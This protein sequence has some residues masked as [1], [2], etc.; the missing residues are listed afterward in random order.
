MTL[1]LTTLPNGLRVITD[2]VTDI[3]SAALGVWVDVGTRNENLLHNGVAHMV[4]HM[5]FNG[6]AGRTSKEIAESIES[7]GGQINAYTSREMTAYYIHL[8]KDDVP[9][10]LEVLSDIIQHSTFPDKELEKE[11]DV[12]LQEIGMSNDTPDD[13]IY[14]IYQE[15]AYPEQALGAPILGTADIVS[16]MQKETLFDYVQRFYTPSKLVISAAG[17]I[18]HEET[19]SRVEALFTDLPEDTHQT[20]RAADY[21]GGECRMQKDLEQSHIVLGFQS[22]S[23]NDPEYY[24]AVLLSTILGGGMSSRLFQEVREKRGLVYSV[25]ASHSAFS[26]DGQF[27][28]Y[29][30]TGPDKLPQ[31]MPVLCDEVQK[32]IQEN[33]TSEELIRAKS[34]LRTSILM[35]RES[36]L[37]RANRQAKHLLNFDKKLD[38]QDIIARIESVSEK[39][40]RNMAGRVFTSK[41][42]LAALGPLGQLEAFDIIEQKLAA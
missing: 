18:S 14:D 31:L 28:I 16:N 7:V 2:T 13:L 9:M 21:G 37:S 26:D 6:T 34:Q 3:E 32:T 39:D 29:A 27:E 25:Y 36:M 17:N 12:I 38:I 4:E 19:L 5:M 24:T 42:T 8:L 22:I 11:R 1:Q 10:A 41:P 23:R 15:T 30:G 33:V 40:I 20:Y 35:S